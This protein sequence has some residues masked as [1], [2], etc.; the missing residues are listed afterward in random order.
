MTHDV[1]GFTVG[2]AAAG[3][4]DGTPSRT[5]VALIASDRICAA[6]VFTT[7]QVIAAP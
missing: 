1:L 2:T 6:A 4:R 7:N 5:D 3:V